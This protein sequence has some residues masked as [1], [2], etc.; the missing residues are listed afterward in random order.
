M[1]QISGK[2][3]EAHFGSCNFL[4]FEGWDLEYGSDVHETASR[5][6]GG[7]RQ[8]VEGIAGGSGTINGYLDPSDPLTSQVTSG[9]LLTLSLYA[10]SVAPTAIATGQ[11][12][13]GRFSMSASREGQPVPVSIPFT[14]HGVWT[15]P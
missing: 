7:A 15:L 4:E 2:Y 11:A 13:L 9:T 5:A 10:T 14:C 12:R 8:T 6:G 3:S 1:S